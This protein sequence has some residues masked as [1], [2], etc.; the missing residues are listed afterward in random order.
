M[1]DIQR[2][3]ILLPTRDRAEGLGVTLESLRRL[4]PPEGVQVE[5]VVVD[6][7]SRDRT[8]EL[9]KDF[10]ASA[11]PFE[12]RLAHCAK[13]GKSAA[14]NCGLAEIESDL[15]VFTDDDMSFDEN[16]LVAFIEHFR[17]YD[18]VGAQGRVC[19]EFESSRPEWLTAKA[20]V[21]LAA[22]SMFEN[23]VF[24]LTS[25]GG[26]NMAARRLAS[27]AAGPFREDLGP[28]D[29]RTGFAE[30]TEWSQRLAH[31]GSLL[32]CPSAISYHR[33][34]PARARRHYVLRRQFEVVAVEWRLR[35]EGGKFSSRWSELGLE[36]RGLLG[37]L[38]RPRGSFE[39]ID[40][41]LELAARCGRIWGLLRG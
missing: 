19:L 17:A 22:T 35:L 2:L 33:I 5:L 38:F 37:A 30:D 29:R 3:S 7:A 36:L 31:Q 6:N 27:V 11:P 20:E 25:L 28:E 26:L 9:V 1:S 4:R 18:C 21:L 39:G 24:Q 13:G 32:F 14:L 23:N 16:W 12:V 34:P 15:V 41:G 40:F 8:S 10:A